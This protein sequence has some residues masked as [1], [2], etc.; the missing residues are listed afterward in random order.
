MDAIVDDYNKHTF[1]RN[2]K[3]IIQALSDRAML[4]IFRILRCRELSG[5]YPFFAEHDAELQTLQNECERK[6]SENLVLWYIE[7]AEKRAAQHDDILA[8]ENLPAEDIA[9]LLEIAVKLKHTPLIAVVPETLA[10]GLWKRVGT[11]NGVL[12]VAN[13]Q[14]HNK[15]QRI[16][17][18]NKFAIK[19]MSLEV[20]SEYDKQRVL[21]TADGVIK[22]EKVCRYVKGRKRTP[23]KSEF[24]GD[25]VYTFS[26]IFGSFET[27]MVKLGVVEYHDPVQIDKQAMSYNMTPGQVKD[28]YRQE[29]IKQIKIADAQKDKLKKEKD[30]GY[31]NVH[32]RRAL[33]QI[34]ATQ[35]RKLDARNIDR[36]PEIR[37]KYEEAFHKRRA[38]NETEQ[39]VLINYENCIKRLTDCNSMLI[40]SLQYSVKTGDLDERDKIRTKAQKS[41]S[42][43]VMEI[44]P[45]SKE[46]LKGYL[47]MS[48]ADG[49][50]LGFHSTEEFGIDA[51]QLAELAGLRHI[52][53]VNVATYIGALI[54]MD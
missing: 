7:Q 2:E 34:G 4:S 43:F 41:L 39:R 6:T 26:K 1:T 11:W 13:L 12:A 10:Y 44:H 30:R 38:E 22:F 36:S 37:E 19:N 31:F 9:R 18:Q 23:A 5:Y 17:A 21:E 45:Y 25:I 54:Y 53:N 46:Y 51:M 24:T 8:G 47:I 40:F 33:R 49:E 15:I 29:R 50:H 27:G 52:N 48:N 32:L 35:T 28:F 3:E 42:D 20:L 16:K 14:R